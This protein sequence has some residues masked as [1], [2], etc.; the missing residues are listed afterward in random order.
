M[1]N[2]KI[3]TAVLLGMTVSAVAGGFDLIES[4][5]PPGVVFEALALN[6][7]L[8]TPAK[9]KYRSPAELI[10]SPDG[11]R[12]Y[13]CEQTAKRISVF[14][15]SSKKMLSDQILLPNEVTGCAVSKDGNTLF[16]TC[17]SECWPAGYVYVVNIASGKVTKRIGVGHYPRSPVLSPDG[18]KLFVCNQFSNSVSIIDV[19][20][21]QQVN[22]IG[23]KREPYVL[24]VTP[25]GKALVVGHLL[26]NEPSTDTMNV[27]SSIGIID[28]ATQVIDTVKLPVG[29]KSILGLCISRDGKYAFATHLIGRFTLPAIKLENGW[30]QSN[31]MAVIDLKSKKLLND[32]CLDFVTAGKANPWSVQC[33]PDS[34]YLVVTHAGSNNLSIFSYPDFIDTVV[35]NTIR[36]KDLSHDF[37]VIY[38]LRKLVQ[39]TT[40]GPRSLAIVGNSVYTAGYFDDAAATM[41]VIEMSTASKN[42]YVIGETQL[43]NGERLGESNFYDAILCFQNWQS[44]GSCHPQARTDGFN[45]ILSGESPLHPRNTKSMIHSWWTPPTS[46]SGKRPHAGGID[47][48]IR[49]SIFYDL[50][51]E[52]MEKYALP[53]DTFLMALKPMSS[54]FLEKGQLSQSAKRGKTLFNDGEKAGCAVCHPVPLFTDNMS[55][56]AG[57]PDP[58]DAAQNINTPGLTECW[59]TGPYGHIGSYNTIDEI[60]KLRAHSTKASN[61]STQELNDLV[62][63]LLSL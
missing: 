10:P 2:L 53:I 37:N 5:V 22:V 61:L 31:N 38:K 30:V 27:V 58:Y 3:V 59:R 57:I 20:T 14:D 36:G 42:S 43:Q 16:A 24:D 15:V 9:P 45:W 46:W 28:I 23:V 6:K 32:I 51:M 39:V 49:M 62:N 26:P 12:I 56:N 33:S 19:G 17:G 7:D 1:K 63:Y 13:V 41:E 21:E 52:P 4:I 47:G 35:A 55:H 29:G 48:S 11:S 25:D 40:K 50:M 60:I 8:P 54:P 44:C 18:T 34:K